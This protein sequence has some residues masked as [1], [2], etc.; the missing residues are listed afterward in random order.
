MSTTSLKSC[1]IPEF[2]CGK[3]KFPQRKD[4]ELVYY[5][6]NGT[7]Y[8]CLRRGIGVGKYS[9]EKLPKKS[10]RNIRYIGT[11]YEQ[12][13]MS[14]GVY[15]LKEL[16]SVCLNKNFQ[17]ILEKSCTKKDFS[18]DKRAYNSIIWHLKTMGYEISVNCLEIKN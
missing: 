3:N 5:Q 9:G 7:R 17:K 10:L 2:W 16:Y 14:N 11:K 4:D 15:D 6:R 18:I 12:N 8:E 1:Q 13:F